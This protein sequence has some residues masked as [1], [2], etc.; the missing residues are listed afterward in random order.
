MTPKQKAIL[1]VL[2]GWG[3]SRQKKGNAIEIGETINY[4]TL[5]KN[6]PHCELLASGEAVGLPK[7]TQGG[8][9]VGHLHIGAGRIVWQPLEMINK[10]IR[11]GEFFREKELINAIKN[12]KKHNSRLHLMGLF[13]DGKVHSSL[14]HLFALILLAKKHKVQV[15]VH[16]FL[17]GRDVPEKSASHYFKIFDKKT[18]EMKADA[19]IATVIGRYY[20]MDRDNNWSR[21]KTA[22]DLL[23]EGRGYKAGNPFE[24]VADAYKRG[25]RT[26]YYV[27]PTIIDSQGI[28]KN[29]DSII[30]F[31]FRTDRARQLTM[32][33]VDRNFR[34][35][36][37]KK[38]RAY[39][40]GMEKYDPASKQK[41]AFA[42]PAVKNNLGSVLARNGIR[43]LRIAETEKYAHVT[44]F[45]NSQME[46]PNK[47]E[48]RI[49]VPSPK[50]P[51]YDLKPGMSAYK[52]T[53]K[54]IPE[55]TKQKY[56]FILVNF[57]NPDLVGHSGRLK[58][59]IKAVEIV[60][61]CIGRIINEGVKNKYSVM[62]TGDHGN[63]EQMLY[64]DGSPRP[65]HT[66]NKVPFILAGNKE[67]RK[68]A[69]L[70]DG[71]LSDIAPTI[72]ELFEIKKPKEMTGKSL[73]VRQ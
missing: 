61:K 14:E 27:K 25:E 38:L 34:K 48:D 19:R 11:S 66:T 16:A 45:F 54:I 36:R 73:A 59:V 42:E 3:I 41:A 44:Y 68:K 39:Y 52:I 6:N 5:L 58:A 2:D 4:H 60:D 12:C 69:E 21:T 43:Q 35:F 9:E 70:R 29:N 49:L 72:L 30:F 26:D 15:F 28:I 53:K 22:Y 47:K 7:N 1:I 32:A 13:S 55:I 37:T 56:G 33:F 62:I 71:Q 46:K 63:A 8:S 40:V 57:A 51:S 65:S 67:F 17:D 64:P 10:A 31:N 18:K 24:S 20:A 50:V 23:V